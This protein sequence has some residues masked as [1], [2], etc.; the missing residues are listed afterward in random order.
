MLADYELQR[1][2]NIASNTEMLISLGLADRQPPEPAKSSV[3][4]QRSPVDP[5][6]HD[7]RLQAG[8]IPRTDYD[9]SRS[10]QPP[11]SARD[12]SP[13]VSNKRPAA[14]DKRV[15]KRAKTSAACWFGE[16]NY[17]GISRSD[18]V[19]YIIL[20]LQIKF[21]KPV[22]I[23]LV[24]CII[25]NGC[26]TYMNELFS[27][28]QHQIEGHKSKKPWAFCKSGV[29]SDSGSKQLVV[30]SGE[31][32]PRAD[33]ENPAELLYA[34]IA[35]ARL[36]NYPG[37]CERMLKVD[38]VLGDNIYTFLF[39][40]FKGRGD[41]RFFTK[42]GRLTRSDIDSVVDRWAHVFRDV[43]KGMSNENSLNRPLIRWQHAGNT[44][45]PNSHKI[46]REH[47]GWFSHF[48]L[49]FM[50]R[51]DFEATASFLGSTTGVPSCTPHCTNH[52]NCPAPPHSDDDSDSDEPSAAPCDEHDTETDESEA[53]DADEFESS[54]DGGE[55]SKASDDCVLTPQ[56]CT[57]AASGYLE[58]M[59]DS[60]SNW[61]SVEP[62]DIAER[63]FERL[64]AARN[65]RVSE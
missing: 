57:D 6:H 25:E 17:T 3:P 14:P 22:N 50:A 4:R 7:T 35:K 9:E 26:S 47:F 29:L 23:N 46:K 41:N 44:L 8:A 63:V 31:P 59:L 52:E 13:R 24:R 65:A 1:L 64:V 33:N 61:E 37:F 60:F 15:A 40:L 43:N 27:T 58:R 53:I 45:A 10:D 2:K 21:Q 16:S 20:T 5:K 39:L 12:A 36:E 11:R 34:F 49:G 51:S 28:F 42:C 32:V 38:E 54:E 30:P 18:I 48:L 19:G 56:E 62:R 55:S